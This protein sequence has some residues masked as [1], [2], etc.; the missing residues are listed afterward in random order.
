VLLFGQEVLVEKW[1]HALL[2]WTHGK[3]LFDLVSLQ[4]FITDRIYDVHLFWTEHENL[5]ILPN[6]ELKL[7][8]QNRF[9]LKMRNHE[10]WIILRV[11]C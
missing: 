5:F 4:K 7:L 3:F 2:A 6:C 8:L 9:K 11:F 10:L 1:L